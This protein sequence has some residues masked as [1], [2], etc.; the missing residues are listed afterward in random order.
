M[1]VGA[2]IAVQQFTEITS[3]ESAKQTLSVKERT[4]KYLRDSDAKSLRKTESDDILTVSAKI[5]VQEFTEITPRESA[6][7]TLSVKERTKN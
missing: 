2:K 7:Q 5:A 4:R 3:Q 6:T 1:V